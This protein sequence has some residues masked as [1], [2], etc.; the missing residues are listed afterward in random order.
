LSKI[1]IRYPFPP[2]FCS[3]P[4]EFQFISA[5][6]F[7]LPAALLNIRRGIAI[8]LIIKNIECMKCLLILFITI[9]SFQVFSQK[10]QIHYDLRHTVDP[11][12]NPANFPTLYFEYF[13]NQ[14][15]G[16]A[17]VKPGSFLF[18]MQADFIGEKNNIGK[19]YMQVSQSFR[20][21]W[22]KI[23]FNLQ[24]SG[25]AGITEP[26]Q[27]S[28]YIVNNFSAGL[29]CPFK[30][31]NAYLSSVLNYKY[32]PYNKPSHD[33]LYTLY[34]WKGLFK[35]KAE[36]SGDFSV[37]TENKDHGD[38]FTKDLH[39]KRF[40]F[41]AEPQFW[42]NMNKIFALGTKVNV[43]YHISSVTN[44]WQVYPTV[45]VKFIL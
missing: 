9:L 44:I 43:Y 37:W 28:Y 23:F 6:H 24:Y 32:T 26:K 40:S 22:P 42:Y 21:W 5:H 12:Q 18:K 33:L 36:F 31:G 15:S 2:G 39:G 8:Y 17:F 45:A 29:S 38:D 14:D 1:S 3:I 19:F 27:Y 25:G 4:I 34:W 30:W 16:N 35:Y 20:C 13:K 10:L 7:T 41:F 11:K